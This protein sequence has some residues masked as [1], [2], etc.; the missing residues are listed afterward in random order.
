MQEKRGI[1]EENPLQEN[2]GSQT[3]RTAPQRSRPPEIF[4]V[5]P[6]LDAEHVTLTTVE[7]CTVTAPTLSR[8]RSYG[9]P[10]HLRSPGSSAEAAPEVLGPATREKNR[11]RRE[12][13]LSGSRQRSAGSPP[14]ARKTGLSGENPPHGNRGIKIG[15]ATPQR[16]RLHQIFSPAPVSSPKTKESE[17]RPLSS[18]F[19]SRA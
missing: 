12:T 5:P 13:P 1:S 18:A 14:E 8:F 11:K 15:Q 3:Q 17:L 10:E 6:V 9:G 2:R 7:N 16:N 19:S 4:R